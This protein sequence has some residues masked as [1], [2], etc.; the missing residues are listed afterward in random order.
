MLTHL[1]H[2]ARNRLARA[3]R[4]DQGSLSVEAAILL[5]LLL[6]TILFLYVAFDAFRQHAVNQRANYTIADMLSRQTDFVTP[7]YMDGLE[8]LMEFLSAAPDEDI[9]LRITVVS[10]DEDDDSYSVEWSQAR[11]SN[12]SP[13]DDATLEGYRDRL[14]RMVDG[15]QLIL[16]E[17][18][19]E[20][21][22]PINARLFVRPYN[23]YV[24]TRPRFAPQ[25]LWNDA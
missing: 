2:T 4:E 14:P 7:A 21:Q 22:S 6:I 10:Y 23:T 24:F 1:R 11:G 5:P 16:T 25:L 9:D 19:V 18:R 20:Y 8:G 15:E 17:T 3:W 13:L 12:L